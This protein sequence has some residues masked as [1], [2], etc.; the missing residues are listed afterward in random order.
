MRWRS[1]RPSKGHHSPRLKAGEYSRHRSGREASAAHHRF[2]LSQRHKSRSVGTSAVHNSREFSGHARLHESGTGRR[3][4]AR[5]GHPDRRL[6]TW[7][8]SLR[9]AKW[10]SAV[11]NR[12]EAE[13]AV[14]RSHAAIARGGSPSAKHKGSHTARLHEKH[15]SG[16]RNRATATREPASRRSRLDH[17]EGARERPD[18]KICDA[19]GTRRRHP[20]LSSPRTGASPTGKRLVS[21]AEI[22][23]ATPN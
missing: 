15:G 12:A 3:E 11:P 23:Q 4:R 14:P 22:C 21:F 1:A 7:R 2:R 10:I 17:H 13:P 18:A 20:P 19:L 16:A 8:G 6:F 9:I 5:R